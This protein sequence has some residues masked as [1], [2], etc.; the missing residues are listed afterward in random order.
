MEKV[1]VR[2][3][4]PVSIGEVRLTPVSRLVAHHW[5]HGRATSFFGMKSAVAVLVTTAS[6]TKAFRVSGEEVSLKALAREMP[7]IRR[8]IEDLSRA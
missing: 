3:E 4:A 5:C 2:L 6:G 8:E 1:T 7:A